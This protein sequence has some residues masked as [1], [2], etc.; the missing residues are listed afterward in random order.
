MLKGRAISQ[1]MTVLRPCRLATL[2]APAPVRT[3]T[4][5]H[6]CV[7]K[8][9]F[10]RPLDRSWSTSKST[11]SCPSAI[12]GCSTTLLD[13]IEKVIQSTDEGADEALIARRAPVARHGSPPPRSPG[14][15]QFFSILRHRIPT[16][17]T[18]EI[19]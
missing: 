17:R 5:A 12:C 6:G 1:G 3:V 18:Y 8:C 10:R 14:Q 13:G 9:R 4:R 11:L 2:R 15:S 7:T 16:P 19:G